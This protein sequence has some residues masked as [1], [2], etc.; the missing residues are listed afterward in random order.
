MSVRRQTANRLT[1][2]RTC[3]TCGKQIVTTADTPWVRQVERDGKRQATTYFCSEGCFAASYK[4]IGWFDGKAEERRK[5][6]DRNRDP[7]KERA[8][9]RAY[10]QA[11]REELREKARLRRLAHPGQAAADSA[12]ARRKL[13]AEEAQANAG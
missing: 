10:Q 3:G 1:L 7:E 8:R 6:K 12:Y 5:L 11:H 2:F 4:H 9:N 13:I